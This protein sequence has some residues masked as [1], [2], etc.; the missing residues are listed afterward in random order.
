MDI[1]MGMGLAGTG[2]VGYSASLFYLFVCICL[3]LSLKQPL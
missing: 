3:A 2:P 1:T